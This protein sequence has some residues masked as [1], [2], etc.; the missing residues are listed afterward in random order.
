VIWTLLAAAPL[1][2]LPAMDPGLVKWPLLAVALSLFVFAFVRP[3]TTHWTDV[4]FGLFFLF[5]LAHSHY[6]HDQ[7]AVDLATCI[8]GLA[9]LLGRWKSREIPSWLVLAFSWIV[10][11][12]GVMDVFGGSIWAMGKPFQM[13]SFFVNRNLFAYLLSPLLW[14]TWMRL[15][16][17]TNRWQRAVWGTTFIFLF[18]VLVSNQSRGAFIG[19]LASIVAVGILAAATQA[20]LRPL[21]KAAIGCGV[22]ILASFLLVV[23]MQQNLAELLRGIHP[24]TN[25]HLPRN[26]HHKSSSEMRAWIWQST[27]SSWRE[28]PLLGNGTGSTQ[29]RIIQYQKPWLDDERSPYISAWHAHSH[30]LE[31]LNDKGVAGMAMEAMLLLVALWGLGNK[32]GN[33]AGFAALVALAVHNCVA[34]AS[35]YPASIAVYWGLIGYGI[36]LWAFKRPGIEN[37]LANRAITIAL[38]VI[39]LMFAAL[40]VHPIMADMRT[41]QA[42]LT[43]D[44]LAKAKLYGE[45]LSLWP[46]NPEALDA[47]AVNQA[48][49]QDFGKAIATLDHLDSVAPG[50]K[51]TPILRSQIYYHAGNFQESERLSR[52][53]IVQYPYNASLQDV[54]LSSLGKQKKC[55]QFEA[56]RQAFREQVLFLFLPRLALD[57]AKL[58]KWGNHLPR[59]MIT[60]PIWAP[61][62]VQ[63]RFQFVNTPNIAQDGRKFRQRLAYLEK[64]RCSE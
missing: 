45:A 43:D 6:Y 15:R 2:L 24:Q 50:L 13:P 4:L 57:S 1:A 17:G 56:E 8:A 20:S 10:G 64:Q 28:A 35:E 62:D 49:N 36:H 55:P 54:Y 7:W 32:G 30:Y 33:R 46:D 22:A 47:L 40:A 44:P 52:E 18:V 63:K 31:V 61:N 5:S 23:S 37:R 29:Y 14:F 21:V 3:R 51:Y 12:R 53:A 60:L 16:Q 27:I 25:S 9:Y 34:E 58:F 42:L 38:P 11:I 39:A 41:R 59:S 48:E 26:F 19:F